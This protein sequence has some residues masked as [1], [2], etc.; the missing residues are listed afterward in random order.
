M[1]PEACVGV[2]SL[3]LLLLLYGDEFILLITAPGDLL[4]E[5]DVNVDAATAA[6]DD[7]DDDE[8]EDGEVWRY[9]GREDAEDG[10][11]ERRA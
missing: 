7:D 10:E 11:C 8:D 1:F 2:E 6:D 4:I 3:L 9:S 5:P